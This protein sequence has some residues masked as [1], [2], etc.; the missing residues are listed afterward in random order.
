MV[1]LAGPQA[2]P[3]VVMRRRVELQEH[4]LPVQVYHAA[5]SLG[6]AEGERLIRQATD[7]A[8]RMAQQAIETA[9]RELAGSGNGV[10]GC[11]VVLGS[12][13]LVSTTLAEALSSHAGRHAAEGE[14]YRQALI[15]ACEARGL[16]V[17]GLAQRLLYT[18]GAG[19]LKVPVDDLRRRV[20]EMGHELGP[21]W[22]RDQK[23]AAVVAWTALA[24]H[25]DGA[26]QD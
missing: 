12:G 23:E 24:Q 18:R 6:A 13:F 20:A 14:L 16:P 21:P 26:V 4:G 5:R 15:R 9:V 25:Y 17:T 2:S 3:R 19:E 22:G 7:G 8:A 1:A 11:A 10:V